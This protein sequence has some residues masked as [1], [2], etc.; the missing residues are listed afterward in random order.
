MLVVGSFVLTVSGSL[1][2]SY[3]QAQLEC[4]RIPLRLTGRSTIRVRMECWVREIAIQSVALNPRVTWNVP[5][6]ACLPNATSEPCSS[7]QA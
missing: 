3:T 5:S 2:D 1:P 7:N 4:R 6:S